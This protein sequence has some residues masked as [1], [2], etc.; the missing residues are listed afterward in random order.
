MRQ[1]KIL[2][3][4]I[5]ILSA[6]LGWFGEK[7]SSAGEF[8]IVTECS[9]ADAYGNIVPGG[10]MRISPGDVDGE[11]VWPIPI[12]CTVTGTRSYEWRYETPFTTWGQGVT[13]VPECSPLLGISF[14][15]GGPINGNGNG[16]QIYLPGT[17][18]PTTGFGKGIYTDYTV[19][20]ASAAALTFAAF[21]TQ[22]FAEQRNVSWQYKVGKNLYYCPKIAGPACPGDGLLPVSTQQNVVVAGQ[23]YTLYK[24][25]Y[26]CIKKIIDQYGGELSEDLPDQTGVF[27]APVL[28]CLS[29]EG[30][31]QCNEC[32][33]TTAAHSPHYNTYVLNGKPY[34]SKPFCRTD[35][36]ERNIIPTGSIYPT[37]CEVFNGTTWV[38]HSD[39]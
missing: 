30:T 35:R 18:D 36:G 26:G 19:R 8:P 37:N 27:T 33:I 9:I 10:Y 22:E 1:K 3:L 28:S 17:G 15:D 38:S 25:R 16:G 12:D 7:E 13:L 5:A 34:T 29:P 24:N 14:V 20:T 6:T 11:L 39:F 32:V 4:S 23:S 2:I 21:F 31:G